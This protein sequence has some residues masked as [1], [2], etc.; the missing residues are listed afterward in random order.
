MK[1][2]IGALCILG[3]A[4]TFQ[5]QVGIGTATPK[6]TLDIGGNMLVDGALTIN[7]MQS[8]KGGR[9]LLVRSKSSIPAGE[10][11]LLD[12]N[13]RD[14]GPVNKYAIL[15]EDVKV[16]SVVNLNTNLAADNYVVAITDAVYKNAALAKTSNGHGSYS[17]EITTVKRNVVENGKTVSK[18]FYAVNL[19]F[20]GATHVYVDGSI[21]KTDSKGG[22]W[23][24]SLII[25]EKALVKDWGNFSGSVSKSNN[26][27]GASVSTPAALK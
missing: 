15:V 7:N 17:T 18:D 21:L 3:F 19:D 13:L 23:S 1:K 4:S 10:M 26:Y 25:Y 2:I 22:D 16:G 24:F 27:N 8:G 9:Y 14:I 11:K 6:S 20:K 5:A 12:V